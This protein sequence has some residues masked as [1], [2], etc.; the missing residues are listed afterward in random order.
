MRV[1]NNMLRVGK[2]LIAVFFVVALASC[3]SQNVGL[4]Q[5]IVEESKA[6]AGE[7]KAVVGENK[8]PVKSGQESGLFE[9][10]ADFAYGG[11]SLFVSVTNPATGKKDIFKLG[12]LLDDIEKTHFV[13][14]EFAAEPGDFFC[15]SLQTSSSSGAS[16][17]IAVRHTSAAEPPAHW[18]SLHC[19]AN[20]SSSGLV[21]T[22]QALVGSDEWD[23]FLSFFESPPQKVPFDWYTWHGV[24]EGA[25]AEEVRALFG[26]PIKKEP[27]VENGMLIVWQYPDVAVYLNKN[28]NRVTT[29]AVSKETSVGG[30]IRSGSF[31]GDL[32]SSWGQPS[33]IIPSIYSPKDGF[34]ALYK[35]GSRQ[36]AFCVYQERISWI[37]YGTLLAD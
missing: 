4:K 29:V 17:R 32:V 27:A 10:W 5:T 24:T 9:V 14:K 2:V 20:G 6:A 35:N 31:Y 12:P 28:T 1:K 18:R 15:A 16:A 11:D 34:L 25:T 33:E 30:G 23:K 13:R 26:E 22:L 37:E 21:D 36:V 19:N 8:A 7:N 3:R